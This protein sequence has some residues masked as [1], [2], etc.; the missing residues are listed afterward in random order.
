MNK[1]N[2]FGYKLSQESSA[3]AALSSALV[4]AKI[5]GKGIPKT[6][7]LDKTKLFGFAILPS[8]ALDKPLTESA[9][10]AKIGLKGPI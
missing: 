4:S 9:L 7:E 5:G 3:Q 8:K 2:L 6:P 1:N 10:S